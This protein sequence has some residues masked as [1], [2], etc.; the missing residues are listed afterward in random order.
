MLLFL[1]AGCAAP[2]FDGGLWAIP[3]CRHGQPLATLAYSNDDCT[4]HTAIL[5]MGFIESNVILILS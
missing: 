5:I 2:E 4:T 1:I 3:R